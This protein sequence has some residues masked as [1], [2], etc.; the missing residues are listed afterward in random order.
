MLKANGSIGWG[1]AF[2]V[3]VTNVL[4]WLAMV[5]GIFYIFDY[6]FKT[7]WSRG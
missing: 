5:W 6:Y 4:V 1:T 3:M 7:P 2:F